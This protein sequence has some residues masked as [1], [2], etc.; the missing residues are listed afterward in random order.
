MASRSEASSYP[1]PST[2]SRNRKSRIATI[3][4]LPA[5]GNLIC[6]TESHPEGAITWNSG[7]HVASSGIHN[8]D[9]IEDATSDTSA[10]ALGNKGHVI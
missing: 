8:V 9:A 4:G 3:E 1:T 7:Y 2:E 10:S 6:S 5:G